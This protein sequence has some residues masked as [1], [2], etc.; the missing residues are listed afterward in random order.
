LAHQPIDQPISG[1]GKAPR[2]DAYFRAMLTAGASDLHLK[3]GS[4]PHT[5]VN[6]KII[7]AN[8]PP[9]GLKELHDMAM[10]LLSST[11]QAYLADNGSIDV[12]YEIPGSDRFRINIYRQRGTLAIAVRRVTR[13]IPSFD[14]LHLPPILRTLAQEHQGLILLSGPT[15]SGK[16]TTIAAMIEHIN[17]TRACHVVTIEDPIEYLYEDKKA[18]VNQREIGIDT[19]NFDSA[20]KY[21]MREDPDVVL[22]GEMR[23]RE[24]FSAALQASE[25]GHLVLG[26]VHASSAPQTIT[27]LLDLFPQESRELIRQSLGFNLKAVVCQRLL[28]SIAQGIQRIP[29]VEIMI[30]NPSVR[31]LLQEGRD[32]ELA[33]VI[34]AHEREG[35]QSFTSS[36]RTLIEKE[37]IDPKVA[38]DAAPNVDELKMLLKGISAGRAGLMR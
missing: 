3:A 33:D 12:A 13:L 31:Q 25:T 38:Y 23:D 2:L 34:R 36:L 20:L 27:R 30:M 28:Q 19:Q 9:L 7:A 11:Q 14:D 15:G 26:T 29:A 17:Q 16:S 1:D 22:I 4:P 6:T 10:E 5:R 24:T 21:L 32:A 35:M 18:V 8:H 37:M